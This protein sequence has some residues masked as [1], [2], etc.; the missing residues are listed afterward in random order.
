MLLSDA[1]LWIQGE[2]QERFGEESAREA[3]ALLLSL[4]RFNSMSEIL[5]RLNSSELNTLELQRIQ[6]WVQRRKKGEP[7]AY[8]RGF[9][10][11]YGRLFLVDK[12]VLIPRP[13]TE[14]ITQRCIQLYKQKKLHP[15][16]KGL[17]IGTGSGILALS[18][19]LELPDSTWAATDVSIECLK[20]AQRNSQRL[21]SRVEF[22][23]MWCTR[24]IKSDFD[25]IVSNPPYL[26]L[27]DKM[28]QKEVD[29]FEP[30]LALYAKQNGLEII[31]EILNSITALL[32]TGGRGFLE[33]GHNQQKKI[34]SKLSTIENI[35]I[36]WINDFA[37]IPR[38]LEIRKK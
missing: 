12:N 7:L 30:H 1:M 38:V 24:G 2:L 27:G 6:N 15:K 28:V 35:E 5:L 37:N 19:K 32:S 26:A 23:Q 21:N 4:E 20:I 33:V 3:Y 34:E 17:D 11:H 8:L 9:E 13:E 22:L 14:L 16:L 18:L 31:Y 25:L 36:A 10:Y 29:Q